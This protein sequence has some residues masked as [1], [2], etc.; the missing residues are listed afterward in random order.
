MNSEQCT[1]DD[2]VPV[3]PLS[4]VPDGGFAVKRVLVIGPSGA[5]KSTVAT[6]L[7]QKLS[8]EVIHLDKHYWKPGW[9]ESSKEEWRA[10]V[11]RLLSG[12][13][14]IID[15]N[16]SSTLERRLTF[17]DTIIFLDFPRRTCFW[18]TI[19]RRFTHFGATRPDMAPGCPE[20]FTLEFLMWIWNYPRRSRPRVVEL[21]RQN[22]S[23]K[24]VLV[25]R[26]QNEVERF[27][28]DP[29]HIAICRSDW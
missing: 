19:K 8:L 16:Y 11:D 14:W 6:R 20:R 10:T 22:T 15:G 28:E 3:I 7:G 4:D 29:I 24:I 18:R 1:L 27:I 17:A 13:R 9:I 5:G 25:L 26:S 21:L 23:N 12:D 2:S